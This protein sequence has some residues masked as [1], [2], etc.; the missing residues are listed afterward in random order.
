MYGVI[1]A[2]KRR[3]VFMEGLTHLGAPGQARSMPNHHL[4]LYLHLGSASSS[5]QWINSRV[6]SRAVAYIPGVQ[7]VQLHPGPGWCMALTLST[8]SWK[9][10][11]PLILAPGPFSIIILLTWA[12]SNLNL[13]FITN[14]STHERGCTTNLW[15]LFVVWGPIVCAPYARSVIHP[16]LF[17]LHLPTSSSAQGFELKTF[18]SQACSSWPSH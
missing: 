9:G 18:R 2:S 15:G 7:E 5:T 13:W 16:R 6:V 8:V 4:S 17:S 14:V 12:H 1:L 11:A 3:I 10:G